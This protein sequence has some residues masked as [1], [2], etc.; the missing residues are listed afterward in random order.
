MTRLVVCAALALEAHALGGGTVVRTGV[1]PARARAAAGRL[2]DFDAL[3]VAGFGGALTRDLLPG[4]LF[5]AT[6]VRAGDRRHPCHGADALA[7][8]LRAAGLTVRRGPLAAPGHL[9][10]GA[11]RRALAATGA[12]AVDMESGVL[13]EAAGR[14][15]FAVVRAIVDTPDRPLL[16]PATL[17]GGLRALRALR[18]CGPLLW[19]WPASVGTSV[20]EDISKEVLP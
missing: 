11:E 2:P 9:V 15:P 7:G 8:L 17:T 5:V 4:D 6:E 14:R 13:A 18:R 12:L 16:H 3:A 20:T 10:T 19:R 1:G